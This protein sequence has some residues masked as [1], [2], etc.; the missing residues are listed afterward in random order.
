MASFR[1]L[2]IATGL[3]FTTM[4]IIMQKKILAYTEA[5]GEFFKNRQLSVGFRYG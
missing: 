3:C 4:L 5:K 2:D 1:K